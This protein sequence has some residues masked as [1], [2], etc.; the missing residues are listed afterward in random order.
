MIPSKSKA[1]Y[2][3]SKL[4]PVTY[5]KQAM[6]VAVVLTISLT[7]NGALIAWIVWGK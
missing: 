4:K 3:K 2:D 7:L 5:S 6:N 1:V